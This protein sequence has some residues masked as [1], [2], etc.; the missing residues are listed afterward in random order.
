M[1]ITGRHT[2]GAEPTKW[3]EMMVLVIITS[4]FSHGIQVLSDVQLFFFEE[5]WP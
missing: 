3:P 2:T 5:D 4:A 1:R